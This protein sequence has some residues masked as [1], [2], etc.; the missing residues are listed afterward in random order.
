[1]EPFDVIIIG[2]GV[3]AL[4]A[5][6]RLC[7]EKKVIIFTKSRVM[8]SNSY[9]AQGGIA[10]AIDEEDNWVAHADDTLVAG[11][12]YN[13][14]DNVNKLTS[15][16]KRHI[17]M[18]IENGM[19]FDRNATGQFDLGREGGHLRRRILHA[20]GDETGKAL[21]TFLYHQLKNKVIIVEHEMVIDLLMCGHQ[22]VGV[23]T[24]RKNGEITHHYSAATIIATGGC[25]ELYTYTSNART[26]TGDGMAMAYRAGAILTDMEFIQFHP[27]L[28]YKNQSVIG[29][30]SEAVRGEGAFLQNSKGER[31]MEGVHHLQDLAPR[32]IVAR[33]IFTELEMGKTVFLNIANVRDFPLRFP[34]IYQMCVE[35]G[36]DLE[37]NLL[38]VVPGAHFMMGGIRADAYGRTSV[39][40][41]YAVGEVA[42][43]GVHGANRIA[44]NSLLEG[45]VFG[46]QTAEGLL[47]ENL[48]IPSTCFELEPKLSGGKQTPPNLPTKE[49]IKKQMTTLAGIVRNGEGLHALL[50]WIQQF[51][52]LHTERS[53]LTY[54]ELEITNMLTVSWLIVKSSLERK[55]SM[56]SHYRSDFP[57]SVMA[58]KRK[59][60]VRQ[61]YQDQNVLV[62]GTV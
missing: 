56:G 50:T 43:T 32:D 33:T 40:R 4:T 53:N 51:D 58:K 48:N 44:S 62:R 54:E 41:L 16:G 12:H 59:E 61:I 22:C 57:V 27:T 34:T 24:K 11:S 21:T 2:S 15:E 49:E 3:A 37:Q 26:V 46:N 10:V 47:S 17:T 7:S 13:H 52:F 8:E 19:N 55:E 1:M 6:Y 36:I 38:P 23:I 9:L 5:A 30:V 42:C 20:G 18:L 29:L 45:I 39:S 35:N 60:V 31:L 25:G 28:L 14:I